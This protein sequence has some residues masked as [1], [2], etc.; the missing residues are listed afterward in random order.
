MCSRPVILVTGTALGMSAIVDHIKPSICLCV[1][2]YWLSLVQSLA[3]FLAVVYT[4][5]IHGH[6]TQHILRSQYIFYWDGV[7]IADPVH[8]NFMFP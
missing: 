7:F 4:S 1:C 5:R 8:A 3:Q 6:S 2:A